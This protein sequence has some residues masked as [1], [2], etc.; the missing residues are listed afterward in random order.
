M[1]DLL[2]KHFLMDAAFCSAARV[3]F[4]PY[5][6]RNHTDFPRKI[7]SIPEHTL[8]EGVKLGA[9]N[10]NLLA[11]GNISCGC[12]IL[13][14]GPIWLERFLYEAPNKLMLHLREGYTM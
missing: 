8:N 10:S 2:L 6:L 5:Y 7:S 14:P 3:K 12:G 4:I 9:W 1:K 13:S 11:L